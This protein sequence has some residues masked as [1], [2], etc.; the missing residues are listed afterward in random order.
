MIPLRLEVASDARE[1]A[2]QI[3]YAHLYQGERNWPAL[4]DQHLVALSSLERR[5]ARAMVYG[6]MTRLY[7]LEWLVA[8]T[9]KRPQRL[10]PYV[11]TVL[12]LG[13]WEL[14]WGQ[15][16]RAAATVDEAVKRV[17]RQLNAGAAG[18][19]NACLR[20]EARAPQAWPKRRQ[21]LTWSLPP[22][23][24]GY[25][26]QAYPER[27]PEQLAALVERPPLTIRLQTQ[28]QSAEEI[29]NSLR[30]EGVEVSASHFHPLARQLELG[31]K[32]LTDLQAFKAGWIFVQGEAALAAGDLLP[33]FPGAKVLDAC[34]APGGKT[35]HLLQREPQIQLT[36]QDISPHRLLRVQE[37]CQRLNLP[38]PH[39]QC[40]EDI[41]V[42]E[43]D[44]QLHELA[45]EVGRTQSIEPIPNPQP[46]FDA[47]L[48]DVPCSG[49]G[50]IGRKPEIRHR[51]THERI[52]QLIGIQQ[53]LLEHHAQSLKP[54]GYLLYCTCTLTLQENENQVAAFLAKH[55]NFGRVD[56]HTRGLSWLDHPCFDSQTAQ[57]QAGELRFNPADQNCEGFYCALLQRRP[58]DRA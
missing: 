13:F 29:E 43:A 24:Y 12:Y 19:V 9:V 33:L 23:L 44:R 52:Q 48:L 51:M 20:G 55:P 10:H 26:K 42:D 34:C 35:T 36:A 21:D 22:E 27:A 49:L 15:G 54:G 30:S 14:R 47:I 45:S 6:V 57:I 17:K 50:L 40:V 58:G 38:L 56:L 3:L 5:Q 28:A 4:F 1:A 18:L 46:V 11:R 7:T 37:N 39:C 32:R 25:F 8:Q 31:G 16:G 53:A 41:G 2:T